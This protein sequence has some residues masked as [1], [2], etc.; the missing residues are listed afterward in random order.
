MQYWLS[1][2]RYS[3]P[4]KFL[5]SF[6]IPVF[7]V[8]GTLCDKG[9][10]FILQKTILIQNTPNWSVWPRNVVPH[11]DEF[12]TQQNFSLLF[13]N[14][15]TCLLIMF[16]AYIFGRA[17]FSNLSEAKINMNRQ[18]LFQ[19]KVSQGI[20]LQIILLYSQVLHLTIYKVWAWINAPEK[21]K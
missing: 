8:M 4:Q 13:R 16:T 19:W 3:T 1:V 11:L 9:C 6:L 15:L 14:W 20:L 2:L 18:Y 7:Q 21:V 12:I 17:D 5:S 10:V